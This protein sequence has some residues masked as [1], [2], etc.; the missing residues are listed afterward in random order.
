MGALLSLDVD[1]LSGMRGG[2]LL[3]RDLSFRVA[4]G[5]VL[6]LE[7]ANGSGKTSLLRMIAG[8]IAPVAGK[9]ALALDDAV[10][11][12]ADERARRTGWLGHHDAAKP[13]LSPREVLAFFAR[14][15]RSDADVAAA[16]AA[17]G[18]GAVADLPCQYLSAGQRK[19][20]ALARLTL[21]GRAVWLL[22]EPLA[23]LDADGK[24]RCAETIAAHC[25]DGGIVLAATHEPLGM[26]STRLVLGTQA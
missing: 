16:L 26:E 8:F 21:S 4:A 14:L 23:A 25:R 3:F 6:S 13:Q 15:Y 18:L 12:E 11:V 9:I 22:D 7:G 20:L 5:E 19:R 2:R 24:A 1:R 17:V 10:C